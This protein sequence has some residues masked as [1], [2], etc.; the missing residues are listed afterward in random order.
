LP[1]RGESQA[2]R[3]IDVYKVE[4]GYQDATGLFS[5]ESEYF[6]DADAKVT[7]YH[8]YDHGRKWG[9]LP[10]DAKRAFIAISTR[11]FALSDEGAK[12]WG[13]W[14]EIDADHTE[15]AEAA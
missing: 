5:A 15:I 8:R 12:P 10:A 4:R 9:W 1:R 7:A 3:T 13:A 14:T 6:D 2:V 11:K